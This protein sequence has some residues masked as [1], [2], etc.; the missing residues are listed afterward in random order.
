MKKLLLAVAVVAF[1]ASCK[2]DYTCTCTDTS[3]ILPL[4]PT[5]TTP[6]S[7]LNKSDADDAKTV[8]TATNTA[9]FYTCTWAE[10]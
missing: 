10:D 3:G 4:L 2:K 5:T 9:S 7:N 1:L 6:F 8:C